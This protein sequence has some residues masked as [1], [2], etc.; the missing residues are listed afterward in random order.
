MWFLG[1]CGN[2]REAYLRKALQ[3]KKQYRKTLSLLLR[4]LWLALAMGCLTH[5]ILMT[6]E[7]ETGEAK[8][9]AAIG[10]LALSAPLGFLAFVAVAAVISGADAL[11][12]GDW[13]SSID[14]GIEIVGLLIVAVS[15]YWQ[16]FYLFPWL[17]RRYRQPKANPG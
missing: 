15:G 5:S 12:P 8:L 17:I 2:G 4:G 9:P 6:I 3:M 16:W 10:M 7:G 13:L 11:F 1:M 14:F